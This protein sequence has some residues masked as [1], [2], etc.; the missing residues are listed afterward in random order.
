[1]NE[2]KC[3]KCN[4]VFTVDESG[5]AAI[6]DQ[7]R[8]DEF[9]KQVAQREASLLKEKENEFKLYKEQSKAELA[10]QLSTSKLEIEQLKA[11]IEA[12]NAEKAQLVE[13]TEVKTK[14]DLEKQLSQK[15]MTISKLQEEAKRA[16]TS[17]E[18]QLK[19]IKESYESKLKEKNDL[20][21]YYKDLKTK[22]STK[23]LGETLEQHCEIAF[24]KVRPLGF[25]N[26]YFEKDNDAKEGTKGDYI[27]RESTPDGIEFLSIM[28]EMKNEMDTT[29]TKKKNEDFFQKLD[30]DRTKKKCEY[31]VLVSMLEADNEFYNDGIVDVSYK[32]P[33]MFVIRPQFF[34]PLISLLKN[35]ALNT[36]EAKKQVVELRNQNIDI[37]NF[38]DDLTTFKDAIGKNYRIAGEKFN[39]AIAQIDNSIK[40]LQKTK[41][42]LLGSE[43]NLRLAH[44]KAEDLT[45]KKL[46]KNNPTMQKR[47]DEI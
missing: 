37:S 8:N 3:P 39:D 43:N 47:F 19:T 2:I 35:A 20:V 12:A 26:A 10:N 41:E 1:M 15:E 29:S 34:I 18:L 44:D 33:K 46:T 36:V 27:F 21:D 11:K 9:N 16:E 22:Q 42:F 14:A 45:I 28:F 6:L 7:V 24:N 5:F 40:A 38:E 31:A 32:Y 25:Q 30:S 23:M 13:L 4:E 17:S